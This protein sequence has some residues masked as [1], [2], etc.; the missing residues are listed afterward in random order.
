[1]AIAKDI[2]IHSDAGVDNC[3]IYVD[4]PEKNDLSQ[5]DSKTQ[6]SLQNVENVF[7]HAE[8]LEKT[9]FELDGDE[10]VLISGIDCSPES[11]SFEFQMSRDKYYYVTAGLDKR[12]AVYGTKTN[13]NG[14]KVEK[15]SIEAF[16]T[17]QSFPELDGHDPRLVH[18]L[19]CKF[20]RRAFPGY[21]A[22]VST[23]INTKHFHNHIVLCAYH[24]SGHMKYH[25][26]RDHRTAYDK[27]IIIMRLSFFEIHSFIGI[28]QFIS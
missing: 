6:D 11:A 26:N 7:N 14:E 13:K 16:H 28:N 25:M 15:Q 12:H 23:H 10:T 3:I 4:D 2:A 24:E 9:V 21:K 18:H 20:V 1:M 8:N 22:V 27:K 17:I 5:Y 19:G